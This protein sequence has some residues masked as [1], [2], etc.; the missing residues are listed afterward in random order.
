MTRADVVMRYT[1][2]QLDEA[3]ADLCLQLIYM[4]RA[5]P[6]GKPVA[7]KR[8]A[9]LEAMGRDTGKSQY[10]WLHRR[11]K[12]LTVAT[13]FIE[14]SRKDGS[15][16]YSIGHTEAFHIVQTFHYAPETET[17]VFTLDPRWHELFSRR[18]FALLDWN[19]R[20]QIKR[21][22]EMAKTLQ[23][24]I[25]TSSDPVQ[26]YALDWLMAKM[27]YLSPIRKFRCA[28]NSAIRELERLEIITSGRI[29]RS[30]K[31][32]EQLSVWVP[33]SA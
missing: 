22:Q 4:A 6:L 5:F 2:E 7:L 23:R 33:R 15:T 1:G 9:L 16:K 29:D 20:L 27:Q 26:H 31:G 11:M 3:D 10:Q 21:G 17:Y 30:T 14:V 32:K 8:A 24:L 28:L 18:E 19:K 12:A 25:A 13:F